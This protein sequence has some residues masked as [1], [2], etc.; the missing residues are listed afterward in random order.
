M[1][2]LQTTATSNTIVKNAVFGSLSVAQ[3]TIA[4]LAVNH[5][6]LGT[7][8]F[9][10]YEESIALG[11]SLWQTDALTNAERQSME[12]RKKSYFLPAKST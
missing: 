6:D 4:G 8:G 9:G 5:E 11:R 3:K 7:V 10:E 2:H 12:P 1:R